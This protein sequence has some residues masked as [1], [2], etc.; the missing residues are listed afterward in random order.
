MLH[1]LV[2][3]SWIVRIPDVKA[4]IGLSDGELG[5]ALLGAP[6]GAIAGQF[7]V[8]W[9]LQKYGSK[10]ITVAMAIAW[11]LLFPLLGLA[12]NMLVLM[13]VLALYGLLSGG[14]DVAMNAQ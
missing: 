10:S 6:A 14:L 1:G 11:C 5:L 3:A 12:S 7:L 9:L 13:F 4:H 2:F 8:G